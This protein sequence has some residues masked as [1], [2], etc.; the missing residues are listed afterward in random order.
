MQRKN[1]TTKKKKTQKINK[2]KSGG[3]GVRVPSE[4]P[5]EARGNRFRGIKNDIHD[6]ND[7]T[8]DNSNGV[9]K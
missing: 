8:D 7:N 5:P 6:N 1:K 2:I 4:L 3:Q 9:K